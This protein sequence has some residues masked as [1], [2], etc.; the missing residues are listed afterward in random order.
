MPMTQTEID[1]FNASL[2]D[3]LP[4]LRVY[5]LSL[6]RDR[7]RADN[8]VQQTSLKALAGRDSS[9]HEL[10]RLDLPHRAQ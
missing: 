2:K 9:V 4:R 3:A 7:D 6:T 5:A 1:G 8:L 10:R